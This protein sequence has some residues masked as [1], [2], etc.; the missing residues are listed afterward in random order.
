MSGLSIEQQMLIEQ[1]IANEQKSIGVAYALWFF[2]GIL[3]L[4][5]FYLGRP[6]SALLQILSYFIL[7]GVLWWIVDA[8]L[9]P[10][11]VEQYRGRLREK[12]MG[13]MLA[14]Q[15]MTPQTRS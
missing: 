6:I 12:W 1:R 3:A 8:F 5:R 4:H 2:V 14:N 11:M 7:I 15:P 9:I 13:E 10:G